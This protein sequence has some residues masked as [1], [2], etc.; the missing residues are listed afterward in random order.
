MSPRVMVKQFPD[1]V[2]FRTIF[3]PNVPISQIF[4]DSVENG[5]YARPLNQNRLNYLVKRFRARSLGTVL[6]SLRNDGRYAE[7]DGQHRTAAALVHGITHLD[8]Y[9]YLD[10]TREEEAQLYAEHGD[11]LKQTA[12]DKFKALLVAKHP[13]VVAMNRIVEAAGFHVTGGGQTPYGIQAVGGLQTVAAD[14]GPEVL[15]QTLITL[16]FLY[17]R[18]PQAYTSTFLRGTAAFLARYFDNPN[19]Q[20][21]RLRDGVL[22]IDGRV[23]VIGRQNSIM[24]ADR[25]GS[26][27][28][29]GRA[30][31][32]IHN[33]G[34]G[35]MPL[36]SK[37]L[38]EWQDRF[39]TEEGRASHAKALREKATPAAVAVRRAR[40]AAK[41][42][43]V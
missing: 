42:G 19:Y 13:D 1:D 39:Y 11:Y 35:K 37:A 26:V 7:L 38:P 22:A 3:E 12:R 43:R 8:A 34:P 23:G 25:I 14:W 31:L 9:V 32:A 41:N 16:K 30:L 24:R 15:S 40:A 36:R 4:V 21:D 33:E 28:A 20:P 17:D 27:S 5:G 10:L 6:L 2:K 18:D 29:H